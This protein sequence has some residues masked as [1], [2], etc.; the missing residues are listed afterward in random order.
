M[1]RDPAGN[2]TCKAPW[3]VV[4]DLGATFGK[5]TALNTS[6]MDLDDWSGARIWRDSTR[7]VGD[8]SRSLTGSLENPRIS[9]AGRQFL[10][11][12]LLLLGDR[13]IADL[14]MAARA[15]RRGGTVDDW[16]RVFNRKRN[17]IVNARCAA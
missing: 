11:S 9:E 2:E 5:A 7:C 15:E 6:K 13:Q 12:R 16:I 1:Q 3:L 14:F 8:L 4:K 17:E 10:A